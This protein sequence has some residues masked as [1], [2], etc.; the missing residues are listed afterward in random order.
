MVTYKTEDHDNSL[1]VLNP[2]KRAEAPLPFNG[3]HYFTPL[4]IGADLI[5]NSDDVVIYMINSGYEGQFV[6]FWKNEDNKWALQSAFVGRVEAYLRGRLCF[7]NYKNNSTTMMDLTARNKL[8][9]KLP[10]N[11]FKRSNFFCLGE[12]GSAILGI[13]RH[14]NSWTENEDMLSRNAGLR[15]TILTKKWSLPVG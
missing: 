9:V 5:R 7:T 12:G 13:Q 11:N 4:H 8:E 14:I 10:Y 6:G 3:F 15:C 1:T 2:F